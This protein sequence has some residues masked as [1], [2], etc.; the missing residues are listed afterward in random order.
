MRRQRGDA[1]SGMMR[2]VI[3]LQRPTISVD[4]L[5]D[6]AESHTTVLSAPASIEPVSGTEEVEATQ[7]IGKVTHKITTRWLSEIDALAPNWRLLLSRNNSP[8]TYR[9]FDVVQVLNVWT[10]N[11]YIEMMCVERL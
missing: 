3:L 2:Q 11:R 8:V 4:S 9:S 5:G 1:T 7:V 10:A 6:Y